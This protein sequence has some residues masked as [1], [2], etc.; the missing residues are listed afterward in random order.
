[1]R[2]APAYSPSSEALGNADGFQLSVA[3][4]LRHLLYSFLEKYT[5][6]V[7]KSTGQVSM[8]LEEAQ[9]EIRALKA[10]NEVKREQVATMRSMLRTNKTTVETALANLKQEYEKQ[11]LLV[12]GT[13]QSLRYELAVLREDSAKKASLRAMYSRRY[14]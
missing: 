12:T 4:H 1:M 3:N 11:K 13:V 9:Q 2:F 5:Q 14:E 8:N 7:K 6:V 10:S